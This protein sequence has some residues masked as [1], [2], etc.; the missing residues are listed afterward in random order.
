M[1]TLIFKKNSKTLVTIAT[2]GDR[3]RKSQYVWLS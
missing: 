2:S 3:N 1:G